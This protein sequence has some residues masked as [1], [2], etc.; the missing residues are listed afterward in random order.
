MRTFSIL[1]ICFLFILLVPLTCLTAPNSPP[2]KPSE[3]DGPSSGEV[4]INYYFSTSTTDPD[5][6]KIMFRFDWGDGSKSSW[7]GF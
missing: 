3:P 4:G 5:G 1:A 7:K 2:L 6:D